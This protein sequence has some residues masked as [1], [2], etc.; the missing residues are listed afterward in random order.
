M[1][2]AAIVLALLVSAPQPFAQDLRLR[3]EAVRLLERA[4]V[5]SVPPSLPNLERTV[6]F[7]VLDSVSGPQEGTFSRVVVQGTGRRDEVVFGDYHLINVWLWTGGHLATT[8]TS[9]V[10]PPVIHD[11]ERLTPICLVMFDDED[12]INAITES[13]ADGHPVRCIQFS[14]VA[15]T[16]RDENELCVDSASGTLVSEKLGDQLIENSQ[17]FPFANALYPGRVTYTYAGVP[18][19]EISQSMTELTEVTPDVLAAPPDAQIRD[20]CKTSRRAFGI[21]KPQPEPGDGG[22]DTDLVLR[23]LIGPDAKVH[24]AVVQYSDRPDLNAEA[25]AVI[26]QWVFT[27]AMCDGRPVSTHASFTLHFRAR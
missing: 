14:T 24:D 3:Q 10:S 5:V 16:N 9:E 23:G 20:F 22:G 1:R 19:L 8:R 11:V 7:R 6:K 2:S 21:S 25:L 17:F 15:G 4:N 27:P 18:R 26:Q 13:L 12:V